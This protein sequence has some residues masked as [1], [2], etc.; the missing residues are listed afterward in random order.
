MKVL[1]MIVN[2]CLET[3]EKIKIKEDGTGRVVLNVK[4]IDDIPD[5]NVVID[6]T[7]KHV[8]KLTYV[9]E[10]TDYYVFVEGVCKI[11]KAK[12]GAPFLH[13]QA[14][15]IENCKKDAIE[16]RRVLRDSLRGCFKNND[17]ETLVKKYKPIWTREEM[18]CLK[19][20]FEEEKMLKLREKVN[21]QEMQKMRL[22][23]KLNAQELEKMRGEGKSPEKTLAENQRWYDLVD[24]NKFKEIDVQKIE[25]LNELH[26]NG[27]A[28][29]EIARLYDEN[30]INRVAVRPLADGKYE[31]LLG[32]RSYLRAKILNKSIQAYITDLNRDKLV[33]QLNDKLAQITDVQDM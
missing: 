24:L 25:V 7:Q 31:L 11:I 22:Q 4:D 26:L 32:L 18:E 12:N 10:N 3:S 8:N 2:V 33:K 5:V 1:D 27:G 6:F 29:I 9:K 28:F 20:K 15:K 16:N 14:E 13:I 30:T 17:I 19:E 23:K 21:D